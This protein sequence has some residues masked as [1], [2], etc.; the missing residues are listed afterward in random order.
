M[1]E[2]KLTA[3]IAIRVYPSWKRQM[4]DEAIERG[5]TLSEYLYSMIEA[6]WEQVIN[7]DVKQEGNV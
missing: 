3:I 6:G 1:S 4:G 7:E 2:E 5:Q